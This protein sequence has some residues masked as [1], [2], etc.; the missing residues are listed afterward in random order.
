MCLFLFKACTLFLNHR[1]AIIKH[2]LLQLK[3][4][5]ATT[6]YIKKLCDVFFTGLM[7]TGQEFTKAFP[8]NYG[9]FS[10]IIQSQAIG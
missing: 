1:S 4:E 8:D 9:C 2:S 10:G 3:I 7:E 5:G 6:L